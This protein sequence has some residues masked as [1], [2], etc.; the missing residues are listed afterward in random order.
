MNNQEIIDK[1][2]ERIKKA[3]KDMNA[4]PEGEPRFDAYFFHD[5]CE[6]E[7]KRFKESIIKF[8]RMKQRVLDCIAK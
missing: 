3:E 1:M 8:E 7:L 5:M 6:R 2:Q 4:L